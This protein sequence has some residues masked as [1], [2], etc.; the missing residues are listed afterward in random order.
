MSFK[1]QSKLRGYDWNVRESGKKASLCMGILLFQL[2]FR[3]ENFLKLENK[4]KRKLLS[5]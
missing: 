3:F 5:G 4:Q 2:F 1:L